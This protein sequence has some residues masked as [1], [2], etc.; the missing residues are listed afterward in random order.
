MCALLHEITRRPT[1]QSML[2]AAMATAAAFI[3]TS[4]A[5]STCCS[6]GSGLHLRSFPESIL[7][8]RR[9]GGVFSRTGFPPALGVFP[10]ASD[11]FCCPRRRLPTRMRSEYT[12]IYYRK[13][14]L[15]PMEHSFCCSI[16]YT[17]LYLSPH[18]RIRLSRLPV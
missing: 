3:I 6:L 15:V 17:Q 8:S 10:R 5:S 9:H 13:S 1:R 7:S 11:P 18:P 12:P 4:L 2:I 16:Q 14:S